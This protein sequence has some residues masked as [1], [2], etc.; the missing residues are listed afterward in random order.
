MRRMRFATILA[1]GCFVLKE[2]LDRT[3]KKGDIVLIRKSRMSPFAI[4]RIRTEAKLAAVPIV[5][6][7]LK[8]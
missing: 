4:F 6:N 8:I 5:S 7:Y 1:L 2:V 3:G